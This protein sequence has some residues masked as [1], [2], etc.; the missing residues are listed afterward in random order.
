[1]T[2][3]ILALL[4]LVA[5]GDDSA[6]Q[7]MDAGGDGTGGDAW[8]ADPDPP[9]IDR[10]RCWRQWSELDCPCSGG[11]CRVGLLCVDGVCRAP[12]DAGPDDDGD[13]GDDAGAESDGGVL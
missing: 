9:P 7:A 4:L 6:G 10:D 3:L 1:M 5:C 2:R 11:M 12:V 8:P 13:A